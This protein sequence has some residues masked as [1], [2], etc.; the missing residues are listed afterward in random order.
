MQLGLTLPQLVSQ[1]ESA[2]A[3]TTRAQLLGRVD[4]PIMRSIAQLQTNKGLEAMIQS[5]PQAALDQTQRRFDRAAAN[6][7]HGECTASE[8]ILALESALLCVR[9]D[10]EKTNLLHSFETERVML[11]VSSCCGDQGEDAAASES[12]TMG[13]VRVIEYGYCPPSLQLCAMHTQ[14]ALTNPSACQNLRWHAA[15]GT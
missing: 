10:Q 2:I 14:H 4:G 5:N 15:A 1:I 13:E 9:S 11:H 8:A 7:T 6:A 3:E 12:V